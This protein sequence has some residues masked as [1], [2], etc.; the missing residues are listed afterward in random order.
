MYPNLLGQKSVRKLT[1]NDM[2]QIIGVSRQSYERK[3]ESGKFLA[4]ECA[5]YCKYF[6]KSFDYLFAVDVSDR[7]I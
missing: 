2:A 6:N 1:N 5:A 7:A 4:S 3:M